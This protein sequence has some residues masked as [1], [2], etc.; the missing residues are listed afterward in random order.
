M[1]PLH[2]VNQ[3][4][5]YGQGLPKNL[6][7][8]VDQIF[9][10]L[11]EHPLDIEILHNET[12]TRCICQYHLNCNVPLVLAVRQHQGILC[13]Q[14]LPGSQNMS[15]FLPHIILI[16]LF[17]LIITINEVVSVICKDSQ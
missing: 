14:E 16:I 13:Y 2:L 8:L 7:V 15:Q 6:L 12:S 5:L 4:L 3:V 1:L 9:H 11:L 10:D 17:L